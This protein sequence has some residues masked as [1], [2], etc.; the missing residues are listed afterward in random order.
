M[1]NNHIKKYIYEEDRRKLLIRTDRMIKRYNNENY[2]L[3]SF[4]FCK[5]EDSRYG[6]MFEMEKR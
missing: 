6:I 2:K 4:L 3:L 1:D 5:D